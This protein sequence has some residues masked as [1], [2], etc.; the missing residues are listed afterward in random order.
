MYGNKDEGHVRAWGR[1]GGALDPWD[2]FS[3]PSDS[4]VT[5]L[6]VRY[7]LRILASY[8]IVS[9]SIILPKSI[10]T[11]EAALRSLSLFKLQTSFY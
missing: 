2:F 1:Q 11:P 8:T 9:H 6:W 5:F 4:G 7:D 10:N 3:A